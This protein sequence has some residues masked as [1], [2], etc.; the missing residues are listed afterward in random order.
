MNS[1]AEYVNRTIDVAAFANTVKTA[2]GN[3]LV[4]R[5]IS[6]ND[7]G[8]VVTGIMKLSQRFMLEL[9]TDVGSL[10]Y[11]PQRGT[12]FLAEARAGFW[13]TAADVEQAFYA[14]MLDIETNLV[15]E[16]QIED[17]PDEKFASAQL[18]SVA[19]SGDKVIIYMQLNSRAGSSREIIH[20]ISINPL[21]L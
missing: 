3:Q 4:Q 8:K 2:V 15:A 1:L 5:L 19:F 10:R 16:E 21:P 12:L 20:P 14:A 17:P 9:F 7:S 13:R 6:E 11:L 18:N